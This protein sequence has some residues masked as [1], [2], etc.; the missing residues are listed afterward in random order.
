MESG[1]SKAC[2]LNDNKCIE[3]FETCESISTKNECENA[4]PLTGD[5][6]SYDPSKKCKWS[7]KACSTEARK[8]SDYKTGEDTE[9][10]CQL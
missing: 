7:G 4:K 8:C 10:V 3:V 1:T 5:Q 9:E 2:I 6:L